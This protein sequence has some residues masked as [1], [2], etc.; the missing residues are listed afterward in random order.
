MN[1]IYQCF[2]RLKYINYEYIKT[3]RYVYDYITPLKC[4]KC[5]KITKIIKKDE[6]FIEICHNCNLYNEIYYS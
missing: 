2:N 4:N 3:P 6:N 5:S 1:Y